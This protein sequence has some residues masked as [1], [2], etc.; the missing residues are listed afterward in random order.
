MRLRSA[1]FILFSA[2]ILPLPGEETTRPNIVL[3]VASDMGRDW[4]SCYG[5][6]H[7]SP[8]LDRLAAQ[9]VRYETTWSM[10]NGALSRIT[11]LTGRYPCHHADFP[12]ISQL[13]KEAGYR[14]QIIDG[15]TEKGVAFLE[16]GSKGG[17]F[18]L[19][20]FI[21]AKSATVDHVVGKLVSAIDE[22]DLA[23]NTMIIFT[24]DNGSAIAGSLNGIP[25]QRG[26]DAKADWGAHVPFIVRAP[27]LTKSARPSKDLIDFTDL[28][29][30]FLE[31]AKVKL[32]EKTKLDGT[33]FLP[34]LRGSDDPFKKRNWIYAES[35]DF[36]MIR[37]WH[38]LVDNQGHFH[39]LE[40]DPHQKVEVSLLDKQA[41]HR[42]QRL[43]MILDRFPVPAKSPSNKQSP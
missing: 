30:T 36:R 8:H 32:P 29:P 26:K 33:S 13:L 24:S 28:Y 39:D 31:L 4:V 43:Q 15:D 34:S 7:K 12:T 37:D 38:H 10:P 42:R 40:K 25:A 23:D 21:H 20:F 6:E 9:G 1:F 18:L 35:G 11:L 27:F 2:I 5:A 17:P 16:R 19:L 41:P 3:I 22:Q 14:E